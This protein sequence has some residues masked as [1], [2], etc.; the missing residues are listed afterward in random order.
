MKIDRPLDEVEI[1]VLGALLEKQQSTPDYYPLT[2]KSLRSACNQSTSRE[3]VMDLDDDQIASAVERLQELG[4]VWRIRGTRAD[5]FEHNLDDRWALSPEL[6]AV[7]T[8][9]MLRGPQTPGELRSRSERLYRFESVSAVEETLE[10]E[11]RSNE[12]LVRELERLAGQKERRW[13]HLAGTTVPEVVAR[14]VESSA[15]AESLTSRVDRL[16]E[17]LLN[18]QNRLE[19]LERQLG[20]D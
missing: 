2:L 17:M 7:M 5:R 11:A 1:R 13:T 8:L 16:E 15:V 19:D 3:P 12:P 6:K 4:L 10:E 18:L 14:S 20:V 9:L